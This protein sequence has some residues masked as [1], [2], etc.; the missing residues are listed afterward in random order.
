[1]FSAISLNV[2]ILQSQ[3]STKDANFQEFPNLVHCSRLQ[4][5]KVQVLWLVAKSLFLREKAA[6]TSYPN[7]LAVCCCD[8]I[9][10]KFV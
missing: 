2:Q 4:E 7:A 9:I 5:S 10:F 8:Y 6:E 1:M 3:H